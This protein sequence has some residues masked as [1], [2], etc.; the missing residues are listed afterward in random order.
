M[1]SRVVAD[2]RSDPK[3]RVEYLIQPIG[4]GIFE[5]TFYL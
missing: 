2:I 4:K 5:N 1:S 3:A